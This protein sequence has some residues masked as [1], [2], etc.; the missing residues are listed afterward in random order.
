[1]LFSSVCT[2]QQLPKTLLNEELD[3]SKRFE[4][5]FADL[6]RGKFTFQA[7][8][9]PVKI[10]WCDLL[11]QW[12]GKWGKKP[13]ASTQLEKVTVRGQSVWGF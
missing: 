8:S 12:L 13:T 6:R 11:R 5:C 4:L 9:V 2:T 1:M 3:D 7:K 10:T